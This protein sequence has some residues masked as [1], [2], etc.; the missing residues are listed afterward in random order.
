MQ[1]LGAMETREMRGN[2]VTYLRKCRT[3]QPEKTKNRYERKQIM[4]ETVE[5]VNFLG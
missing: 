1:L 3:L 2:A 4:N 5:R